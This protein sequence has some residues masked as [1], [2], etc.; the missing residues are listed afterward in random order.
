M[1]TV[2]LVVAAKICVIGVVVLSR[3]ISYFYFKKGHVAHN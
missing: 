2:V 1:K 3:Y